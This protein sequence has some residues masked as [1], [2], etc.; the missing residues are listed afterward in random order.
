MGRR[1][2][3]SWREWVVPGRAGRAKLPGNFRP[4]AQKGP[5]AKVGSPTAKKAAATGVMVRLLLGT[6][7]RQSS[8]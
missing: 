4:E 7:S 5:A 6:D 3:T 1:F 2:T 8:A